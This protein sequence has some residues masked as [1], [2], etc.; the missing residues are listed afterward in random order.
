MLDKSFDDSRFRLVTI[1]GRHSS[2]KSD[3]RRR[4]VA[5]RI[6]RP[7][8]GRLFSRPSAEQH[9]ANLFSKS[10]IP[11]KKR[12]LCSDDEPILTVVRPGV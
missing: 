6:T 3:E 1:L 8:E 12:E 2:E 7:S 4:A 10:V 5:D 11:S 9:V